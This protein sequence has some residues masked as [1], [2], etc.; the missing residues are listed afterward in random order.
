M[1]MVLDAFASYLQSLMEVAMEELT[2]LPG[3]SRGIYMM[4]DKLRDL[5]SFL[6]DADRRC[7]APADKSVQHWVGQLKSAMYEAADILDLC[8]LKAM[9]RG[10]STVDVGCF[11]PLLFCMW[12]NPLYAH[13]ISTRIRMLTERLDVI[14][15]QAADFNFIK[16]YSYEDWQ[17]NASHNMP[18]DHSMS[19]EP[20][21]SNVVGEQ[22]KED[23]RAMV[24][25]LTKNGD[26]SNINTVMVVAIVGAGGIGKTTLAK[27]IFNHKIINEKFDKKIWLSVGQSLDNVELLRTIITLVGGDHHNERALA[28]LLPTLTAALTGKKFLL[29]MDDVWSHTSWVDMLKIPFS[30]AAAQGTRILLTTRDENVA[31]GMKAMWP[32]HRVDKLKH[33]DGWLLLKKQ[34][35]SKDTDESD[36]DALK[37]IGLKIIARCDGLPLA[38]K[39]MGNILRTR[40]KR[41]H[42]WE[43][44]LKGSMESSSELH[45]ELRHAIY[46]SYE[47]LSPCLKQ[48]FLH[49]CLLPKNTEFNKNE[50]VG[51][52]ISEGYI[53]GNSYELEK[54]G[55]E[56]Y[57]ELIL[58]NLIETESRYAGSRICKVHE[59]VRSFAQ[60]VAR[61]EALLACDGG[62]D[63]IS[64]LSALNF[65]KIS[66]ETKGLEP[67]KLNW[68]LLEDQTSLRTLI[69]VGDFLIQP[70]DSLSTFSSLRTL[71]VES[72]DFATMV[73]SL[74]QL[75]HLRYLS[76]G[77]TDVSRLPENISKLK[78]LQ[79]ISVRGCKSLVKL[80]RS[81]VQ[82]RQLRYLSLD[83]SSINGIPRGFSALTNLRT[84]V[85]FPAQMDADWCSLE[86]LG[87]LSQ[88]VALGLEELENVSVPSFAANARLGEKMHLEDLS[89]C[90]R[91][92]LGSDGL[93][94]E[95]GIFDDEQRRIEKIFDVLCPPPCLK[96]LGIKR[97]FGSQLPRWMMSRLASPL[98][99][100][101][102][103]TMEYL[104]CCTQLPDGLCELPFLEL[105]QIRHA[106]SI[107]RVG[108]EFLQPSRYHSTLSQ[109]MA[110]FPRLHEMTLV[111]MVEWE[112]WEWEEQVQ[113]MPY[114][115][116]LQLRCC[117]LRRLPPGLALHARDL[118]KLFLQDVQHLIYLENFAF[119]VELQVI[120]SPDLE[121]ISNLTKLKKLLISFCP[122]VKVLESLP[123]LKRLE[124]ED[125]YIDTLPEYMLDV[126]PMHL[127]LPTSLAAGHP[128]HKWEKFRN[129]KQVKA[130]ANDGEDSRIWH[131][132]YTRDSSWSSAPVG[133]DAGFVGENEDQIVDADN[134]SE[135]T[136]EDEL[137]S[138]NE[139]QIVDAAKPSTSA[140]RPDKDEHEHVGIDSRCDDLIKFLMHGDDMCKQQQ[141]IVSLCGIGGLGKTTVAKA[142]YRKIEHEFSHRAFVSVSPGPD[143][144]EIIQSIFVQV[145]C[146]YPY[147]EECDIQQPLNGLREYLQDKKRRR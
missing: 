67:Y 52:W 112:E 21:S 64:K 1:A 111:G 86:E 38:I 63:I 59:A 10:P 72:A 85:G 145:H 28:V 5:K 144:M 129:I 51:M 94:K 4:D 3:I 26:D 87:P 80:P 120:R 84:L 34:A 117:R 130:S 91:S 20:D 57:E 100:L 6:A 36:I 121:R 93:F 17:V 46:L 110:A 68:K 92:R 47:D 125:Y 48:C 102:S 82:L 71:H 104:D 114:L 142:A 56:Y 35:V 73:E 77:H 50:V 103:L 45:G 143:M 7:I 78:F 41:E 2:M 89:L 119:L 95:E 135:S 61:D 139:D 99:N 69:L 37:D 43:M 44:V 105:F 15:E 70:G 49:Y 81:I 79:H 75:K 65:T 14:K 76:I 96:T 107:K 137:V 109:V 88:L 39:V 116:E 55:T 12:R 128:G 134:S 32:Y 27:E 29:V 23:T 133:K 113:A 8:Q 108:P 123:E 19:G 60:Y 13:D 11:N 147:S 115:K 33:E 66:I 98:V 146:P 62:T 101:R 54:L 124:L 127:K 9:E 138:E 136:D 58:R 18:G 97:Y 140:V 131:T 90:C 40:E 53:H 83:G 141:K 25:L 31:R 118:K 126:N 106:P 132:L 16:P 42:D 122:K 22:I 74:Y 24:E 30:M